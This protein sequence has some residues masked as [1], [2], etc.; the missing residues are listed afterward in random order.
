MAPDGKSLITSVGSQDL[1]VWLHDKDGDHQIS[2]EG[3]TSSPAFSS[4][5][6]NLYFLKANGQTRGEELWIKELDSGKVGEGLAR[7]TRC[8]D[9]PYRET[10]KKLHLP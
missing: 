1:T 2:S 8:R 10:G 3:N 9:T 7:I 5:G 6:R 4:D